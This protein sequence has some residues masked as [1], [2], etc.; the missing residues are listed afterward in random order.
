MDI[1][2]SPIDIYPVTKTAHFDEVAVD[3]GAGKT[4]QQRITDF[5]V[6]KFGYDEDGKVN[7]ITDPFLADVYAVASQY[8]IVVATVGSIATGTFT[9]TENEPQYA[10]GVISEGNRI[11]TPREAASNALE[12][13]GRHR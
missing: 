2:F 10:G 13:L 11:F 8:A 5:I 4:P 6:A 9:S 1:T 7:P 3:L 12:A